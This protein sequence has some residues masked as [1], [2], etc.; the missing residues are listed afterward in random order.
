MKQLA[1]KAAKSAGKVLMKYYG[2]GIKG[3]VKFD[4]NLVSKADL[5]AEKKIMGI[6]K[7]KYPKH[8]ILSEESGETKNNPEYRWIIDP[9]DGTH[10]YLHGIPIFAVSIALEHKRE[11]ILGVIYLP[12]LDQLFVAEKG[13]GAFMDGKRIKVSKTNNLK[14]A[15]MLHDGGLRRDKK[16]KLK[17]LDKLI[18]AVFRLRILGAACFNLV[19]IA[20]GGAD[21][22]MEH[23]TNPWDLAAG[24]L[25]IE[26]AGGKVTRLDGKR[27]SLSNEGFVAS[28]SRLH[29]SIIKLTKKF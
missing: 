14:K 7:S 1:I 28:N 25:I 29:N 23:S 8:S 26:E 18:D 12:Y 9:L 21:I 4:D 27:H 16:T 3:R 20:K 19:S 24:L 15:M 6:I 11:V 13:K 10:N 5:E 2:K 22:Y 17:A